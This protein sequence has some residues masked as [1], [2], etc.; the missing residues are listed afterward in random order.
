MTLMNNKQHNI[1]EHQSLAQMKS[2]SYVV[3]CDITAVAV[4]GLERTVVVVSE[5][6]GVVEVC[7]NVTSPDINCPIELPFKLSLTAGDF[8]TCILSVVEG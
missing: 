7:V 2:Q 8:S 6:V 4:V 3:C 1:H 5:D